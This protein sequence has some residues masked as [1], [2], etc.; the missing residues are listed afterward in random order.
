M[1]TMTMK[2]TK[3]KMRTRTK[4]E[5]DDEGHDTDAVI[6]YTPET[7]SWAPGVSLPSPRSGCRATLEHTGSILVIGGVPAGPPLRFKNG[8]WAE[9]AAI[10][11]DGVLDTPCVDTVLIW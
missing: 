11:G 6:I 7:D 10:P 9:L 1:V 5:D 4:E 8:E 3:T 2:M